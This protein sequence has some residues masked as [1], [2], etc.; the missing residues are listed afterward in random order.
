MW[1]V[2]VASPT[3]RAHS[4]VLGSVPTL[5]LD[6]AR[7]INPYQVVKYSLGEGLNIHVCNISYIG[8]IVRYCIH[9]NFLG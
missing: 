5:G 3:L 9:K 6:I 2:G 1:I 4:C 8:I 7:F